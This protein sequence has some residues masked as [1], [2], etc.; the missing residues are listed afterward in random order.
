MYRIFEYTLRKH[1]WE[2]RAHVLMTTHVHLLVWTR[3]DDISRGMQLVLGIYAQAFN[4]EHG[5]EGHLVKGRFWSK[6]V[7]RVGYALEVCRYIA[8]NPVRAGLV[9]RPEQWRWSSYA[10]TIGH[11]PCPNFLSPGWVLSL[12]SDDSTT[13]AARFKAFVDA[14]LPAIEVV[15][16]SDPGPPLPAC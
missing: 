7:D 9:E 15:P 16:G 12:F 13:A 1:A 4:R 6:V 14:A 8:L 2:I 11:A 3:D 10:A 5:R